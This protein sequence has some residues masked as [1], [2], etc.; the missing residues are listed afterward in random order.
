MTTT[1]NGGTDYGATLLL[2]IY[3]WVGRV[4]IIFR[5]LGSVCFKE[6]MFWMF[7]WQELNNGN[8]VNGNHFMGS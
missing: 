4:T 1:R 3:D 5:L 2:D 8:V 6:N 7:V